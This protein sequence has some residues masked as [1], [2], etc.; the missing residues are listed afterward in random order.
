MSPGP[1][2]V[3][4]WLGDPLLALAACAVLA[5]V[6]APVAGP[7]LWTTLAAVVAAIGPSGS[8]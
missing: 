3:R 1:G 7:W 2:A 4:Q 8:T 5:L 6:L